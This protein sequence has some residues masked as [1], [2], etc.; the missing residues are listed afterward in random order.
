MKLQRYS[1]FSFLLMLIVGIYVEQFVSVEYYTFDM[2]GFRQKL[3]IS[4]WMVLPIFILYVSSV[5]HMLVYS[6]KNYRYKKVISTDYIN[7]IDMIKSKAIGD[8]KSYKFKTKE[9]KDISKILDEANVEFVDAKHT[10]IENVDTLIDDLNSISNSQ[11]VNLK[12]YD[13][14]ND[15]P[16]YK[17]NIQKKIQND[18]KFA[19]EV[20]KKST[21]YDAKTIA[22]AY[23]RVIVNKDKNS[24]K[25]YIDIVDLDIEI[26]TMLVNELKKSIEFTTQEI[27]TIFKN[28]NL[29]PL[30]YMKIARVL[31]SKITPDE[32]I[33]LTD[34]LYG[35]NE[36]MVETVIFVYLDFEMIEK[37]KEILDAYDE[38]DFTQ[39]RTYLLVKEHGINLSISKFLHLK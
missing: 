21:D 15:N 36:D 8:N 2:F 7:T 19:L 16:I 5:L 30:E 31:K 3:P 38:D 4:V 20:L 23:K 25:K 6:F 37:A 18:S 28:S 1:F 33:E 34:K 12:P 9:F 24:I 14:S 13:L 26:I 22:S 39:F 35:D 27:E 17:K 32:I 29:S 11:V 10:G